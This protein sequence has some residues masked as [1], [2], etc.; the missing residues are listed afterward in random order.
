MKKSFLYIFLFTVLAGVFGCKKFLDV[1]TNPV[2]PQ[3][4]N[5][6]AVFPTQIAAYPRG[7]QWD[8]RYASR[9]IQNFGSYTTN[10]TNVNWDRMGYVGASDANGDIWRQAYIGFGRNLKYIIETGIKNQQWDYVGAALAMQA[11]IYQYTTDYHGDIIFSEAF[12]DNQTAFRFDDQE[13]VYKGI[14]SIC[15]LAI[16][17]LNNTNY[18]PTQDRLA[19]GD[20]VYNGN[21]S[22]WLKYTYGILARNFH[23]IS[24]KASYNPDSVIYYC[25]KSLATTDDDFLVAF[26]ATRNDDANFFG[27][28]RNNLADH[29]QS[30]FIV[31]LLDGTTLANT[32]ASAV[33]AYNR[34][35]RMRH[36]LSASHDTTNGNGGYRGVDPG[37]GDPYNGLS[38][39]WTYAVGSTSYNNAR[40]KVASVWGDTTYANPSASVFST[41]YQKYLFGNKAVMPVMTASEIQ[42]MKSEAAYKKGDKATAYTA[43][44]N[45]INLHFDFIN[46]PSFP[47]GNTSLFT[48]NPITQAERTAYITGNNV[49]QNPATLRL[50]DIMLQKYI[51]LWGWGFFETWVDLRRYHYTDID[52]ETGLQVYTGFALPST[53]AS[54]NNGKPVYRVRP[55]YNSEYIWNMEE[56]RRLGGLNDDYHTYECWFSQP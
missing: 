44:L 27:T 6:S 22:K 36:M 20:Y 32:P 10:A 17:Y 47:R 16:I 38:N 55:R 33:T 48:N 46:R 28:Y 42:F 26:D 31:R 8:G 34:D 23:R 15:R 29:R 45:G 9:Y 52:P 5:V 37:I 35:P 49:R 51:A 54:T 2:V 21:V 4:P 53:L 41:S 25:D 19:K 40:K 24:N 18:S 12:R 39:W 43:Y 50:S 11:A 14:D 3:F 13:T 1:N 30:N 56:L 7:L